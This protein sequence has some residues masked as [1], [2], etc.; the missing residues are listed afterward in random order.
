MNLLSPSYIFNLNPGP[1]IG[2][3][4]KYLII[5]FA[6]VIIAGVIAYVFSTHK[7]NSPLIRKMFTK[8]SNFLLTIGIIA[9]LLIFF[10]QQRV[11]FLSMPFLLYL[12]LI[13]SM[14]W[15]VFVIRFFTHEVPQ[16]KKQMAEKKEREKYLP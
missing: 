1:F 4:G 6:V 2:N 14:A 10:R 9:I 13:G 5:F 16:R 12:W 3:L 7:A 8:V 11:Q 15:S